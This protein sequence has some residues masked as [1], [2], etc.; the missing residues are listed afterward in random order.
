MQIEQNIRFQERE[1]R[2][3][4]IGWIVFATFIIAAVLGLF[5]GGGMFAQKRIDTGNG[6]AVEFSRFERSGAITKLRIDAQPN[7]LNRSEFAIW[8]DREY[9]QHFDIE[10]I[11]PTPVRTELTGE[12][13]HFVFSAGTQNGDMLNETNK[14][15]QANTYRISINLKA[16]RFG[17]VEGK[18]GLLHRTNS[19]IRFRQ[20]FYP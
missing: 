1:W 4:R 18:M 15:N 11:T 19:T 13:L 14:S 17:M 16:D 7:G 6:V 8:I 20:L 12:T 5:G 9:F 3:Q 10:S 2:L